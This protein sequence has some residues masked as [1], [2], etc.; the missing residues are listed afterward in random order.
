[1]M[2]QTMREALSVGFQRLPCRISKVQCHYFHLTDEKT[3]ALRHYYV[4]HPKHI[5]SGLMEGTQIFQ[6]IAPLT[7]QNDLF[8]HF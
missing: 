8:L 6:G 1:M 3:E 2:C 4:W 7:L 5:S